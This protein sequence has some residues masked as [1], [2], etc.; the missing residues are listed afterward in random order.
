MD[1]KCNPV[2]LAVSAVLILVLVYT[3][4]HR[5]SSDPLRELLVEQAVALRH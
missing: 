2:L 5:E 3:A 4:A 1:R